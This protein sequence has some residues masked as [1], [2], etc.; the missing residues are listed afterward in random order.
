MSWIVHDPVDN[1]IAHVST[2][3]DKC[4]IKGNDLAVER[5]DN[6]PLTEEDREPATDFLFE[7]LHKEL[8]DLGWIVPLEREPGLYCNKCRA[9]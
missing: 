9:N 2:F 4:G 8:T 7:K 3:C 1:Q 6:M 5:D